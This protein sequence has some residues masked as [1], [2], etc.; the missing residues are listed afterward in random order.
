MALAS[1][2]LVEVER[3]EIVDESINRKYGNFRE[4]LRAGSL[5]I[6]GDRQIIWSDEPGEP[7]T[8]VQI[9]SGKSPDDHTDRRWKADDGSLSGIFS[10]KYRCS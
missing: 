5:H 9:E 8:E 2:D 7:P 1:H 6:Q 10:G 4:A 3:C